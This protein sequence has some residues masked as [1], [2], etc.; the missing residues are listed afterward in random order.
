MIYTTDI[1]T[2]K[3]THS[4]KKCVADFEK[5]GN[6]WDPRILEGLDW[7]LDAIAAEGEPLRQRVVE[8]MAKAKIER[9]KRKKAKAAKLKE[10][11][12]GKE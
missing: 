7:L 12:A 11:R 1:H 10:V 4:V 5:N 2:R 3:F 6:K 9:E 8:D